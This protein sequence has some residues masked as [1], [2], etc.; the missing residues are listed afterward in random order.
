MRIV[1][2]ASFCRPNAAVT[3][4]PEMTCK[5]MIIRNSIYNMLGLGLPLIAAVFAIPLLIES[6]GE[7]RF[8]I[9]TLIWAVVSYFGLFDLGLGRAVTQQVAVSISENRRDDLN[10]IIGTSSALMLV[11][12][13]IG[14]AVMLLFA[15]VMGKQLATSGGTDEV[16][17]SF[18]WMAAAMPSIV[19]TSGYRGI[20]EATGQFALVNLIRVPMGVFTF[21]G[22]LLALAGGNADLGVIAAILA[23]GRIVGCVAHGWFALRELP[24]VQWHGIF[25]WQ[26][27]KPMLKFGGWV[28]S[29][30][31]IGPL[32]GYVDRFIIGFVID[33]KA[34]TY[35]VTPQ[36]ISTKLSLIPMALS[37][38]LFPSFSVNEDRSANQNMFR[39]WKY[40][41]INLVFILP[42]ALI[43][44]GFSDEIMRIWISE[45]FSNKTSFILQLFV[46]GSVINSVAHIPLTF[47]VAKNRAKW[48]VYLYIFE[49]PLYSILIYVAAS[50]VGIAGAVWVWFARIIVDTA[51]V[52]GLYALAVL[53]EPNRG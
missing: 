13:I 26:T 27:A 49:L 10:A 20:M 52:F 48:V 24:E 30:N 1:C 40:V 35:F 7:A 19:L 38:A 50:Q 46:V 8:G 44:I 33:A 32:I 2:A 4:K 51:A 43:V 41:S 53:K 25:R 3:V 42:P 15:P 14:G 37:S 29:M 28:S 22:P 11:L 16:V 39:I 5:P 47:I 18:W 17:R 31:I 6:L 45:E 23:A 34:A 9:L 21:A 12:G 36:E